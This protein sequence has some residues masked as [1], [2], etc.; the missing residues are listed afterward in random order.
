MYRFAM[1]DLKNWKTKAGRKPLV[2]RGARQVG[3]SYLV[4]LFAHE[5]FDKLV[6]MNFERERDPGLASLFA[7]NDPH[8]IVQF[9]ELRF[10]TSIKPGKTLLFLDEI[11]AAPS[12]FATLRYFNEE[13]PDLH[14]IAAG[15]IMEFV[16]SDHDFSVPVGRIEYLH[17]GPM[18][19]EEFLLASGEDKL[20]GFLSTWTSRDLIPEAIHNKLMEL[21]RLFLVVGG[22][23]GAV[24]AYVDGASLQRAEEVKHSILATYKDDFCKYGSRVKHQRM[25]TL[26]QKLP[27]LVGSR[28][29]YAH[30]DRDA[31]TADLAKALDL[32]CL[33]RVAYRVRHSSANGVPLGAQAKDSNFK[34]LFLDVG[35]MNSA[36]G[37]TLLDYEMAKDVLLVHAGAVCRQVVGQHLLHLLPFYQEPELYFWSREKANAAA[38]VD[39]V[40]AEGASIVPVEVKAGTIG[41]LK[42]LQVFLREKNLSFGIRLNGNV[43]S[44]LTASTSLPNC[45]NA[46]FKLLSLP[47]YLVGQT[48]RLARENLR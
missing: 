29:K 20:A 21:F 13:L 1:D 43:P 25:E 10:N 3:K 8:K 32:L 19:F 4:R 30:V 28:F 39:Y 26:F 47:L 34:A 37:F 23:P 27:A 36:L 15:S 17:L 18:Q 5:N 12:V 48:R 33:A 35:L 44:L 40:L 9:L 6:E 42:S 7:S 11:Q 45:A 16:L 41:R 46:S 2:V 24:A 14:V 38:E 22:M 31:R